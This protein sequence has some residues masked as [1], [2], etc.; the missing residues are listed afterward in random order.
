MSLQTQEKRRQITQ[1]IP[2]KRFRVSRACDQCRNAREKCDAN[3]PSCSPCLDAK[4]T[5]T[6]TSNPKKR[7]LQPGY[8]RSLE[9]TLAFIFQ[10]HAEI[11]TSVHE[12]LAQEN[13]VLLARGTKD[14]NRLHKS[15][16]KSRFCR[17]VTKALSGEQI[18]ASEDRPPSS[19]EDSE[20]DTEDATL[21]QMTPKAQSQHSVL[22]LIDYLDEY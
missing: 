14:S 2:V 17:D 21:L 15:W 8:I 5:C 18:G 4:R 16:T 22:A 12:Q 10:Q 7:G 1:D 19:D 20:V 6:Y 11:E 3:Q 9:M 13:T